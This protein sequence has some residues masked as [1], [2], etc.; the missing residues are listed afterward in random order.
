[1][2]SVSSCE[3]DEDSKVVVES[4][5]VNLKDEGVMKEGFGEIP[6]AKHLS[7]CALHPKKRSLPI[8]DMIAVQSSSTVSGLDG[9]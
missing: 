8:D 1:L 7:E 2:P 4:Q 3:E 9:A 6:S 5:S